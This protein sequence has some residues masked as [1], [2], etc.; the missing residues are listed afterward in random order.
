MPG[1]AYR[2]PAER[3]PVTITDKT[4]ASALLP[5]TFVTEGASAFTAAT[6]Y[7]PMLRLLGTRDYYAD[8]ANFFTTTDPALTAYTSGDTVQAFVLEPG[9]TYQVAMASAT[10][11]F[12]QEVVVAAAGRAAGA[13]TGGVVVGFCKFAGARAAGALG[14]IEICMPY[15]KA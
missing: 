11:A 7:G 13:A 10:Y 6:A 8:V 9:Q 14:D 1:R 5:C 2:G 3:E 15:V 4:V 12:G